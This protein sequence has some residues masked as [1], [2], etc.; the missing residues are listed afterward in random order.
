MLPPTLTE[1]VPLV[2]VEV[3]LGEESRQIAPGPSS[4]RVLRWWWR[5]RSL[6]SR[7]P[8]RTR[9]STLEEEMEAKSSARL[10]PLRP[11]ML[12]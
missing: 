10:N 4:A 3:E 8:I 2:E 12:K 11:L 7:A 9:Q 1:S 6:E 5:A